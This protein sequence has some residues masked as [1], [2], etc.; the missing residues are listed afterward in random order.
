MTNPA[1]ITLHDI[2]HVCGITPFLRQENFGV[3]IL[4][5]QPFSMLAMGVTNIGHRCCV[6]EYHI[7][8]NNM[9]FLSTL[10]GCPWIHQ[11]LL[12]R[13]NPVNNTCIIS[14]KICHGVNG[15]LQHFYCGVRWIMD[16]ILLD[17]HNFAVKLKM[18]TAAPNASLNFEILTLDGLRQQRCHQ[19]PKQRKSFFYFIYGHLFYHQTQ[20]KTLQAHHKS[21]PVKLYTNANGYAIS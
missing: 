6:F 5:G 10:F 20:S 3:T 12:E 1:K 17:G 19:K 2:R 15:L 8:I 4:T 21:R 13:L 16:T 11:P 14:W 7:K 9:H 18:F